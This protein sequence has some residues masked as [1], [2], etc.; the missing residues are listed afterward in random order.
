MRAPVDVPPPCARSGRCRSTASGPSR[1]SGRGSGR[2]RGHGLADAEQ[3]AFAV[4]EPHPPLADALGRVVPLDLG[5]AVDGPQP[6]HVVFLEHDTPGP[7]LFDGSV[8]V[9]DLPAHLRVSPRRL[10]GRLEQC[11][12]DAAAFV[13]EPA[14][15]L[16]DRL[17]AQL[18][19]IE[20]AR[21]RQILRRQP[22]GHGRSGEHT[23]NGAARRDH[24]VRLPD[25]GC[26]P[27]PPTA[28][29]TAGRPGYPPSRCASPPP[30][31]CRPPPQATAAPAARPPP[32]PRR[33][34]GVGW[35]WSGLPA[36]AGCGTWARARHAGRPPG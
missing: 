11:E 30:R 19:G 16:L 17:E 35:S 1:W 29:P 20:P 13:A 24:D 25:P 3:I 5:D 4:V 33:R 15:A 28:P 23:G 26:R 36:G 34:A 18:V 22:G 12:R 21:P 2:W 6:R 32:W 9:V 7:Q 14:L 8:D 27:P 31:S 10:A